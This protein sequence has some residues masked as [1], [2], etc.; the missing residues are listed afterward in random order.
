MTKRALVVG[1]G[2]LRGAYDAGALVTLSRKLGSSYFDSV[3]ASSVGVFTSTFFVSNQPDTIE[4]TWRNFVHSKQIVNFMNPLKGKQILDIEY[5]V[6]IFQSESS[7]LDL[8]AVIN[9][10]TKLTYVLTTYPSGKVRYFQ[11]SEHNLFDAMRASSALPIVHSPVRVN[12]QL[13]CDGGLTDKLPIKK[14]QEDGNEE[15][16]VIYN[17]TPGFSY[18][19]KEAITTKFL[20]SALPK[21]I[22]KLVKERENQNGELDRMIQNNT[23]IRII[24]PREN[25]PLTSMLDTDKNRINA[26]IDMGITDA[27]EFLKNYF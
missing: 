5:L 24:R 22:S 2:G 1:G 14:A 7:L 8:K 26:S 17:K 19:L 16:I 12:D 20:A 11:P 9:S 13:F 6:G 15:I 21:N 27:E 23:K 4:N 10:N 18:S 25:L 3:Y